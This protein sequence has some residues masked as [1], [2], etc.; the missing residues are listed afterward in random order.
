MKSLHSKYRGEFLGRKLEEP[1]RLI[2]LAIHIHSTNGWRARCC[3]DNLG[4]IVY[5][6]DQEISSTSDY[7][8]PRGA[9]PYDKPGNLPILSHWIW[10]RLYRLVCCD[11]VKKP[12]YCIKQ[13]NAKRPTPD[14]KGY[15]SPGIG[16]LTPLVIKDKKIQQRNQNRILE[17]KQYDSFIRITKKR[18]TK[19]FKS[20]WMLIL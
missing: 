4:N 6:Q 15:Q 12:E 16:K 17:E 7:I 11:W 1:I 20:S 19:C 2:S 3:Y 9:L 8:S 5:A 18:W 13:Y 10:D 14:I